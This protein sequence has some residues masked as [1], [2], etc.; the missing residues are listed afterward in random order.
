MV[1]SQF[2]RYLNNIKEYIGTMPIW[3]MDH[4]KEEGGYVISNPTGTY[5]PLGHLRR[6]RVEMYDVLQ[7]ANK[8]LEEMKRLSGG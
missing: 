7:F 8:T 5:F 3:E 2:A 6:N 4:V 1:A